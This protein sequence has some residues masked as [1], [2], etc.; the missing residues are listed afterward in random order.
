M[1]RRNEAPQVILSTSLLTDDGEPDCH[2]PGRT[3]EPPSRSGCQQTLIHRAQRPGRAREGVM[4]GPGIS[5]GWSGAD[6]WEG[7][8]KQK[9]QQKGLVAGHTVERVGNQTKQLGGPPPPT[10]EHRLSSLSL[11]IF[12]CKMRIIPGFIEST[13]HV[14]SHCL[15]VGNRNASYDGWHL[16]F[17]SPWQ[18]YLLPTVEGRI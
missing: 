16:N 10:T 4:S 3:D 2:S 9:E 15:C 12:V 5:P 1:T 6:D 14:C 7:C 13:R 18:E 11:S 8:S 17:G